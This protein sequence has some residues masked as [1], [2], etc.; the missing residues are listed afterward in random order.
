MGE[1]STQLHE[2]IRSRIHNDDV[3]AQATLANEVRQLTIAVR[4]GDAAARAAAAASAAAAAMASGDGGGECCRRCRRRGTAAAGDAP[5]TPRRIRF[6]IEPALFG[7]SARL[8]SAARS[9]VNTARSA[10]VGGAA[11]TGDVGAQVAASRAAVGAVANVYDLSS[12]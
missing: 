9:V 11:G 1:I 4:E 10:A 2:A 5:S 7:E 12:M 6:N 3:H 8:A